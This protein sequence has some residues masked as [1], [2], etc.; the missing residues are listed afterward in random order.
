M[1]GAVVKLSD[2]LLW[3]RAISEIVNDELKNIVQVEH[4][5]HRSF[6]NFLANTLAAL[7]AC[8]FFPEKPMIT[9]ERVIDKQLA[10]F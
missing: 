1:K 10:L 6:D 7:V 3:K 9:M 8:C 2:R 4:F 5:R